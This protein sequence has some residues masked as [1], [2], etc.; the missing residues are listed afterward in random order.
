MPLLARE[1]NARDHK[2]FPLPFLLSW[3]GNPSRP[4]MSLAGPSKMGF[5]NKE[6]R[7]A[8]RLP[9]GFEGALGAIGAVGIANAQNIP[10]VA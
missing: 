5:L 8:L 3:D 7:P 4:T 2:E 10:P 9:E 1:F 6:P